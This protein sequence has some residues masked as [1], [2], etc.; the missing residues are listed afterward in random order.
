MRWE[1]PR[2]R[3]GYA[4]LLFAVTDPET[5]GS[6]KRPRKVLLACSRHCRPVAVQDN[7]NHYFSEQA[8]KDFASGLAPLGTPLEFTETRQQARGGMLLRVYRVKFAQKTL[9]A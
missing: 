3:A 6:W 4:P 8:L 5:T 7:A 1:R 9:Q 2:N